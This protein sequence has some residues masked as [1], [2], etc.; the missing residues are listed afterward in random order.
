MGSV[1]PNNYVHRRIWRWYPNE[2]PEKPWVEGFIFEYE[3]EK[4]TYRILYD[5]NDPDKQESIEEGFNI[6]IAN[7]AEFV[8]GDYFDLENCYGSRRQAERPNPI[9]LAP[10]TAQTA[11]AKRRRSVSIKVPPSVPFP[12]TWLETAVLEA[13]IDDL[14]VML[15]ML[16]MR[17]GELLAAIDHADMALRMGGDLEKRAALERQFE[18]LC[19]KE[20]KVMDEL[21]TLKN[22]EL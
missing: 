20:I 15:N 19:G 10:P 9:P 13:S 6:N 2:D 22:V 5:P 16:E 21:K 8:L 7:P 4:G 1:D 14:H 12:P 11:P 17:E 3:A 18:E